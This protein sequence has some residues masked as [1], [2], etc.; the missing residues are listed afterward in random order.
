MDASAAAGL[1]EALRPP[2]LPSWHSVSVARAL[3]PGWNTQHRPRPPAR[4]QAHSQELPLLSLL[5]S[6]P[7]N[8]IKP[9]Q[10]VEGNNLGLI[11]EKKLV[12]QRSCEK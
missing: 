6:K 7:I 9:Q 12:C 10:D 3:S 4:Q 11:E 1:A 5:V 8:R 2:R